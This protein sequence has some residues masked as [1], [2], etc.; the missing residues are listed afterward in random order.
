MHELS[1]AMGIVDIAKK[2]AVK[3]HFSEIELIELEIGTLS[4]V[5]I[6]SFN[7]AWPLAVTGTVLEHAEKKI[8]LIR[9]KARCLD[10]DYDYDMENI[11][12]PC[13]RCKSHF[14]D[15]YHGKELRVKAIVV[16]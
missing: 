13:P 15:I 3:H 9:G 4:G 11:F 6:E 1:I 7:F 10:C 8:D 16:N 12:D 2:E 5:E 14:K